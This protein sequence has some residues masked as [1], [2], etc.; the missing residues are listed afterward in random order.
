M[1]PVKHTMTS[2]QPP[3]VYFESMQLSRTI[4][5]IATL[6]TFVACK[7]APQAGPPNPVKWVVKGT[8]AQSATDRSVKL[9]PGAKATVQIAAAVD[10]GWY[11]YSLTQKTGGPTPMS[12]TLAPSP[13]FQLAGKITAPVPI[14]VYDKEFGI[15]TE[16][17]Q[18]A[19]SFTIP[20]IADSSFNTSSAALSLKVRFQACNATFCLPARTVTLETPIRMAAR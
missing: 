15:D 11:I 5:A 2:G 9:R 16:R 13:P 12:V 1:Q 14:V 4:T 20:V 17:Y 8:S 7:P 3:D 18:G 19:P 10:T 6:V